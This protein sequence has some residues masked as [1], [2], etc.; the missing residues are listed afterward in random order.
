M[1]AERRSSRVRAAPDLAPR[2]RFASGAGALFGAR[3]D[4]R[5]RC[6]QGHTSRLDPRRPGRSAPPGQGRLRFRSWLVA[7]GT[8]MSPLAAG[9]DEQRLAR[10]ALTYLAEPGGPA[11]GA[12]PGIFDPPAGPSA[13]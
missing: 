11:L 8:A 7:R 12:L 5:P 2:T 3:P 6:R 4:K 9:L 10:A 1:A 13:L